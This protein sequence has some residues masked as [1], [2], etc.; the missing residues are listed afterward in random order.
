MR[1][2]IVGFGN[3]GQFLADAILKRDDLELAFVWNRTQATLQGKVDSSFILEDLDDFAEREADLIVEVAHPKITALYGPRF[4]Q[5]ADYLIGSPTAVADREIESQLRNAAK[6][7]GFYIPT[8]AFWGGE[9]IKRMAD[10]GALQALKI[11]M[12]KHPRSFKVVGDL[13]EKRD[14][15]IA[16]GQRT[17]LYDGAVR[18][19][20]PLAPNNVN[21]MAAAAL[22]AHTL[23]FDHVQGSII[24]DASVGDWHIVEVET[25]GPG[26]KKQGF[27][28]KTVRRNPAP[29]GNVTGA[30]TYLSFVGSMLGM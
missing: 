24:A 12:T 20:C 4:L 8:G 13:V 7:H 3:L 10:R 25:W 17:V 22:A 26:D 11:T 16:T 21:T 15:A 23:G 29:V 28:V 19:L 27:H 14:R 30:A 6:N 1:I 2:G 9:D 5:H 18:P